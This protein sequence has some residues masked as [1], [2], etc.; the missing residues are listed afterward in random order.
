MDYCVGMP[1]YFFDE[2]AADQVIE[3]DE[4]VEL[5]D[6]DAARREAIKS[7]REQIAESAKAGFDVLDWKFR[8]LDRD[9]RIVFT[10]PFRETIS[11]R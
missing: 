5:P 1:L 4:G 2:I 8:V 10:L 6:L 9:R 7:A 3:D 11:R